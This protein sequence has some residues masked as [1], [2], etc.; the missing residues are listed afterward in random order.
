MA[1]RAMRGG[2]ERIPKPEPN[3]LASGRATNWAAHS[4]P[5]AGAYGLPRNPA[6]LLASTDWSDSPVVTADYATSEK[7]GKGIQLANFCVG[8]VRVKPY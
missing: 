8:D 2:L 3:A 4:R 6:S 7:D 1:G 5:E